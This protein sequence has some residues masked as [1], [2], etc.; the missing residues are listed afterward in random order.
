MLDRIKEFGHVTMEYAAAHASGASFILRTD[1]PGGTMTDRRTVTMP[2][3]LERRA[4]TLPF[5]DASKLYPEGNLYQARITSSGA[6]RLYGGHIMV[7]NAAGIYFDGALGEIWQT[8]EESI[9]I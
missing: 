7:R 3:A 5:N 4:I 2:Q 1:L 8:R 9:G 6:V